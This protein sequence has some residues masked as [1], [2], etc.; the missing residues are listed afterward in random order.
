MATEKDK[1]EAIGQNDLVWSMEGVSQQ[2]MAE[3]IAL[4]VTNLVGT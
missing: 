3:I 1:H 2:I 4:M